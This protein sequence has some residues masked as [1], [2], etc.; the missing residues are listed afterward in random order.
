MA[1]PIWNNNCAIVT[2]NSVSYITSVSWGIL[3]LWMWTNFNF[4]DKFSQWNR[5]LS[6]IQ[7]SGY[8][9]WI[10][11][12]NTTSHVVVFNES[13]HFHRCDRINSRISYTCISFRYKLT[14][15]SM[16]LFND[17]H[18]CKRYFDHMGFLVNKCPFYLN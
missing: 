10:F 4:I 5:V 18:S 1:E 11:V 7:Q 15:V 3:S 17:L 13:D 12:T 8:S 14:I 16:W 9:C 6:F 2:A